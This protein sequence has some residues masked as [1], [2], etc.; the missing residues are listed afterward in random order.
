MKKSST[1]KLREGQWEEGA[2]NDSPNFVSKV[3]ST[4][5][6]WQNK[7]AIIEKRKARK[8]SSWWLIKHEQWRSSG[9]QTVSQKPKALNKKKKR[10]EEVLG[11][12][13]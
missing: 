13:S 8:D 2:K 10:Q 9:P 11:G 5:R 4:R 6:K 7:W 3:K 1:E 12:D